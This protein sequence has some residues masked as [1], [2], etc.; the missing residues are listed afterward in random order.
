VLCCYANPNSKS[1]TLTLTLRNAQEKEIK[2]AYRAA[3]L[4]WHPDKHIGE[5]EK[6]LA[7]KKFQEVAEAHE[8][9]SDKELRRK[10]DLGEDVFENQGGGGGH[11]SPFHHF[12]QHGGGGQR[13]HFKM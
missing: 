3:A 11:G 8:V 4:E 6:K 2:K 10:Y 5:E 9:L 13:F 7:E 12:Q 1:L